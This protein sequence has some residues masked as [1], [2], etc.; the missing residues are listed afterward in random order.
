[1]QSLITDLLQLDDAGVERWIKQ[2]AF[3]G[4]APVLPPLAGGA[5][6]VQGQAQVQ[7]QPQAPVAMPP[8]NFNQMV[9]PQAEQSMA[10]SPQ[11][12]PLPVSTGGVT[13][14]QSSLNQILGG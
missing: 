7:A 9:Q 5:P 1:M 2:Q 4:P 6:P 3:H 13:P 8:I 10:P 14:N 12:I 11:T